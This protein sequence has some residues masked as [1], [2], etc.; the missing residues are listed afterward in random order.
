[1]MRERGG[2]DD[3]DSSDSVSS[4]SSRRT[5]S[6]HCRIRPI[7]ARLSKMTNLKRASKMIKKRKRR[8]RKRN[9]HLDQQNVH[10]DHHRA[11]HHSDKPLLLAVAIVERDPTTPSMGNQVPPLQA[12]ELLFSPTERLVPGVLRPKP[13]LGVIHHIIELLRLNYGMGGVC[14]LPHEI[15]VRSGNFRPGGRT[16]LAQI[17]NNHN[18]N[19]I[20]HLAD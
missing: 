13:D 18:I 1:M 16:V 19:I 15:K 10:P 2:G 3:Y 6:S 7:Q 9:P 17:P 5:V 20:D 14:R 12:L 4:H 8:R 11:D